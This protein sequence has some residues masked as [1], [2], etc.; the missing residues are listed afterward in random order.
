[1]A[2]EEVLTVAE[3]AKRLRIHPVTLRAWLKAGKV[4]GV[5]MGGTRA[6]WRIPASEVT[7]VLAQGVAA[8]GDG[9]PKA[10]AA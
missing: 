9:T 6:G 1:M 3:V 10:R 5:R 4:R 2:D 7:R 8:D